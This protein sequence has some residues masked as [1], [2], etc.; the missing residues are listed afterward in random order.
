MPNA[1]Q[2]STSPYLK[3]HADNPVDWHPWNEHTLQLARDTG[4][5]ILLSIGYSACHWCHVMAHESFEDESIAAL[6]NEHFINIKVDREER[7]DLDKL[8]Q[9]AQQ[10]L[11]RHP[12]GW[13]LTMFLS[14][15]TRQPFFGGTYFPPEP[16]HG[17]P[18]F[19][20]LLPR[21]AQYYREHQDEVRQQHAALLKV[22]DD[23]HPQRDA[24][25]TLDATPLVL[26]RQVLQRQFDPEFGGFGSAPKFPHP[27]TLELLLRHWRTTTGD[28]HPDLHALYMSALTLTRMAEGGLYDQLGGGFFRYS[29]DQYWMIP[30]FEKMLYDNAELLRVYAQAA[31]ATGDPLFKRITQETA[32]WLLR[33]LRAPEGNFFSTLDADSEGHE[34][35]YY[36]WDAAQVARVLKADEYA[37][38][39]RRFG[40]DQPANFEGRWHLHSYRSLDDVASE[41]GMSAAD[42]EHVLQHARHRLLAL[43]DQRVPPGLDNKI[44]TSWNALLLAGL[45]QAARCLRDESLTD[46][47]CQLVDQLRA[48]V[49]RDGRLYAVQ[50]GGQCQFP[51]YLDD[52]AYLLV[53]LLELLQTRWRTQDLDWAIELA[54]VM[55]QRFVD[56]ERGGFHFTADDHEALIHRHKSFSDD[57][58]PS[59]NGMAAQGLLRL[60]YLLGEVRYL[61]AA[62]DTVRSAGSA[63]QEQPS[64]HATLLVALDEL[65]QAPQLVILR[66]SVNTARAWQSALDQM[67][68]PRRMIFA[69]PTDV[70]LPEAL[71]SKPPVGDAVAYVCQGTTCGA[72]VHT[73]EALLALTR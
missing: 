25:H 8:Y 58:T 5:P 49:W 9:L 27:R 4:K 24:N 29:V 47:A 36:A 60:G 44:L 53:G 72:P 11:T 26:A 42:A 67:Y 35:R 32:G 68:Q 14:H 2:H 70:R 66:G 13:P 31:V 41:L 30:H 34:G 16:R 40:L 71:R 33:T 73:L 62:E 12:G 38:L 21:V 7:P 51:A 56:N 10:I 18:G 50:A 15:D 19:K 3:Q 1:L 65:L 23:L 17:M 55:L 57:A 6:M 59:G 63:L 43:R 20:Q 46:A 39:S 22:F 45:C 54:E 64:A 61:Q 48:H 37:V 69:I 28:E 52:H